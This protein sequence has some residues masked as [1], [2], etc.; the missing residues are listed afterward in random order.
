M[1]SPSYCMICII[2]ISKSA[3]ISATGCGECGNSGT[4]QLWVLA[5][6]S[7]QSQ[8]LQSTVW[9]CKAVLVRQ[10]GRLES[11]RYRRQHDTAACSAR[12]QGSHLVPLKQNKAKSSVSVHCSV[13]VSW[14]SSVPMSL[15]HGVPQQ[16]S[17][18]HS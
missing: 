4:R 2:L 7:T 6:D 8:P 5:I 9:L 10:T 3:V 1:F 15:C 11:H 14:C 13:P 17:A 12:S 16:C 18:A